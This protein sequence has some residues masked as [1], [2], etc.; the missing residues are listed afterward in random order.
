MNL[1][2]YVFILCF[3]V[4]HP[5]LAQ[6]STCSAD[7]QRAARELNTAAQRDDSAL[8]GRSING[9]FALI[10]VGARSIER[11][12]PQTSAPVCAQTP[13]AA[14]QMIANTCTKL[15][16][17]PVALLIL[18]LPAS[19]KELT[20]LITHER[21]HCLQ[22]ELKLPG[23]EGDNGHLDTTANRKLLRMEL[24]ALSFAL[25]TN[26]KRWKRAAEDAVYY[27]AMRSDSKQ[28]H[29]GV[30]RQEALLELNEGLAEYSGQRYAEPTGDDTSLIKKL[31]DAD[32]KDSYLRSFAYATG[33]AYGRLLDRCSSGWQRRITVNDDLP[34]L[35]AVCLRIKSDSFKKRDAVRIGARYGLDEVTADEDKR[36]I[37]LQERL[38]QAKTWFVTGNYLQVRLSQ[39]NIQF[40]PSTLFNMPEL[41]TMYQGITLADEWGKLETKGPVLIDSNWQ[42]VRVPLEG[43]DCQINADAVRLELKESYRLVM[44]AD[45]KCGLKK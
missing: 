26:N 18:P 4:W 35:L 38:N 25:D 30:L 20:Q 12:N 31:K 6:V 8:W 9:E 23:R 27:R 28:L 19:D 44:S 32:N 43:A 21:W 10:N 41:G 7:A 5:A 13:L 36:A 40:N 37:V 14:D 15:D 16:G 42:F 2:C 33:P 45:K 17:Q 1:R 24:R 11:V 29:T 22:A 3:A 34:S 39:P